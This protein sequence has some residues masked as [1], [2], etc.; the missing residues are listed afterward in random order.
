MLAENVLTMQEIP[1]T[2]DHAP[3]RTFYLF[4]VNMQKNARM[5]LLRSYKVNACFVS[6]GER[7]FVD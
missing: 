1:K 2:P 4:A 5:L 6:I 7:E 3:S